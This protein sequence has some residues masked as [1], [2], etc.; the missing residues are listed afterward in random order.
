MTTKQ[1][2]MVAANQ[3]KGSEDREEISPPLSPR[4]V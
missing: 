3:R 4:P 2:A 1:T